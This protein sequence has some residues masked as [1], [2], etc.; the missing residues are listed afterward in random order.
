M[1]L[2]KNFAELLHSDQLPKSFGDW[3]VF[4][5]GDEKYFRVPV[6][7]DGRWLYMSREDWMK[8]LHPVRNDWW[9]KKGRKGKKVFPEVRREV[10]IQIPVFPY[11]S[12]L[13]YL[14]TTLLE[15]RIAEENISEW[16]EEINEGMTREEISRFKTMER[17]MQNS[18]DTDFM[19][20]LEPVLEEK[21]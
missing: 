19:S 21:L 17:S 15:K 6:K 16:K 8:L 20:Y 4:E 10:L 5:D 13:Y 12:G 14:W 11:Y 18:I 7:R 3:F 1:K 2:I 9:N